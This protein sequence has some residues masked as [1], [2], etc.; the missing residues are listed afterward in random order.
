MSEQLL[1]AAA[2]MAQAME[3]MNG[4]KGLDSSAIKAISGSPTGVAP[5][6]PTGIFGTAGLD[7]VVINAHMSP[8]GIDRYLPVFPTVEVNPMFPAI[9]GWGADSGTEASGV[10][11]DCISNTPQTCIQ[12]ATFGRICRETEEMEINEIIQRINRGVMTDLRIHGSILGP[13]PFQ[14][15]NANGSQWLKTAVHASMVSAGVSLQRK[16]SQ[17]IWS[18]NPANNSAGGGY[19]EFPGLD[20]LIATGKQDAETG[21]LCAALDPDIKSFNYNDV[22]GTSPDIVEY[23]SMMEIFLRHNAERMG[24]MPVQW[25]LAM[26]PELFFELTACWP[27][28][29]LT[30]RCEDAAGANATVIN[31]NVNVS[32]R[33]NMRNGNYLLVNGRQIPVVTDDGIFESNNAND[34]NLEAGQ[35]ASDIYFIPLTSRGM[36]VTYWE[37]LDYTTTSAESVFMNGTQNWWPT[38][39]GR[40]LWNSQQQ[41]W[42]FKLQ[43]KTEPRIIMRTPQLAGRIQDVMYSPLQHLR[44]PF[45][46]DSAGDTDPYFVKGGKSETV[47]PSLWSEW[48]EYPR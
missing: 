16:I 25:V 35:F 21:A 9:T 18:G 30:F 8:S 38:D 1:Q 22:C 46:T 19:K 37:H 14:P 36:P 27:C 17:M 32:L 2:M 45:P 10:C 12:T 26:R 43:L 20:M 13:G 24:L 44:S 28:K 15:I 3:M 6:G 42:C 33:D 23:I 4:A 29:Y 40:F 7:Q 31:D 39:G 5:Y 34:A 41:S 48:N 11:D 47:P